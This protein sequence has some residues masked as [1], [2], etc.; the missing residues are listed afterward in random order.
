MNAVNTLGS[1]LGFRAAAGALALAACMFTLA[2]CGGDEEGGP[3]PEDAGNELLGQLDAIASQVAAG[4]CSEATETAAAFAESVDQLPPEVGGEL[5][6]QLVEASVNL[7]GLTQNDQQCQ[8]PDTGATDAGEVVPETPT[9]T[10]ETTTTDTETEP[11]P[12]E[13][14][15]EGDDTGEEEPPAG[16]GA[17]GNEG[18]G[19]G[20]SGG[21]GSDG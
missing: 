18:S 16:G 10:T 6:S 14:E 9:T 12:T 4:A 3:I 17:G 15:D 8:P 2:A 21:I 1:M 20:S 11:P 13:E 19:N 7:E 5:R